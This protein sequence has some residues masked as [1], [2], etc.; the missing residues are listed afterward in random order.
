MLW[1]DEIIKADLEHAVT[2]EVLE[3]S[4]LI[5]IASIDHQ[6][7][8]LTHAPVWVNY[9]QMEFDKGRP[10]MIKGKSKRECEIGLLFVK[11]HNPVPIPD[12]SERIGWIAPLT[13]KVEYHLKWQIEGKN[14]EVKVIWLHEYNQPKL[15]KNTIYVTRVTKR[16]CYREVEVSQD[17]LKSFPYQKLSIPISEKVHIQFKETRKWLLWARDESKDKVFILRPVHFLH[18]VKLGYTTGGAI[19]SADIAAE[20]GR[21]YYV[22]HKDSL[23][24]G[25]PATSKRLQWLKENADN[26]Y[27]EK[28]G[29]DWCMNDVWEFYLREGETEEEFWDCYENLKPRRATPVRKERVNIMEHLPF[30]N[31]WEADF[32][33]LGVR[34]PSWFDFRTASKDGNYGRLL[35]EY[36]KY[37]CN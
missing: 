18:R 11:W 28:W 22:H 20:F 16:Q 33:R 4:G 9:P 6:A 36:N 7:I 15:P 26:S 23:Y 12:D 31:A 32:D 1:N 19:H 29:C 21:D 30:S 14:R 27:T 34:F 2:G 10:F 37:E 24:D 13:A 5:G 35:K 8:Q 3:I 17:I 25:T